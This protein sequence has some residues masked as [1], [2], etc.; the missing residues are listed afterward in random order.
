M[1]RVDRLRM[2]M[3]SLFCRQRQTERLDSELLFHL[4]EQT[5][6]NQA[7]GMTP[8]EARD[9]ALRSFGSR[10]VVKFQQRYVKSHRKLL[11]YRAVAL[12]F[13]WASSLQARPGSP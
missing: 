5:K 6:E 7:V 1:R 3:S 2:A 10:T 12:R 4:E 11:Q 9:A 13:K 8:E